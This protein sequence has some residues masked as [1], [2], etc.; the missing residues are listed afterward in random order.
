[1]RHEQEKNIYKSH[2]TISRI[3][4]EMYFTKSKTKNRDYVTGLLRPKRL[5]LM[6]TKEWRQP[7]G[8]QEGHCKAKDSLKENTMWY[9]KMYLKCGEYN[10]IKHFGRCGVTGWQQ[11]KCS[12]ERKRCSFRRDW[13]KPGD[14]PIGPTVIVKQFTKDSLNKNADMMHENFAKNVENAMQSSI[15]GDVESQAGSRLNAHEK[16]TVLKGRD[17]SWGNPGN[18][19]IG[20]TVIVKQFTKDSL[21]KNAYMVHENLAKNVENA[22][23]SS[24][25]DDVERQAGSRLNARERKIC[26][27]KR[28]CRPKLQQAGDI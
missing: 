22:M 12:Q 3:Y 5:M 4:L 1:M 19:H 15:L 6:K 13:S 24:I 16:K 10:A 25:L 17:R 21:N 2:R 26:G 8:G 20:P 11:I 14:R 28:T 9:T 23:Q 27:F 7:R 18:R